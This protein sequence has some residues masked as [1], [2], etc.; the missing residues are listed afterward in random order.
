VDLNLIFNLKDKLES[1]YRAFDRSKIYPDPIQFLHTFSKEDDI[2]AFGIIASVFS[3]GNVSQIIK[4]L[5][6]LRSVIGNHPRDFIINLKISDLLKRLA[7]FRHRFFNSADV[8]LFY[9]VL[10]KI[11]R[12]HSSLKDFVFQYYDFK[13]DSVK[14]LISTFSDNFLRL[15]K[16]ILKDH[17]LSY[18]VKFMFPNPE[19]GSACKRMNLFLRW[20][21][22]NDELDFGLWNEIPTNKLIIP[23]DIHIAKICKSLRLT[24]QKRVSWKMAEEITEKLKILDPIDPIKYDFALSHIGMRKMQF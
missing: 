1:H 12:E 9:Q 14:N 22:R 2:E 8:I 21:V 19:K 11:Y 10:Q 18:G 15:S 23:V 16:E 24:N 13:F 20:M 3:Y 17:E 4:T 6:I 7:N 5:D